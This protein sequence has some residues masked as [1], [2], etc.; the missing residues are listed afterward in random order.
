MAKITKMT[1]KFQNTSINGISAL[2]LAENEVLHDFLCWMT[3]KFENHLM[4][5][6]ISIIMQIKKKPPAE[7]LHTL[8]KFKLGDHMNSKK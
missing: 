6:L 1:S 4:I 2:K 7:F 3:K 5:M 8:R